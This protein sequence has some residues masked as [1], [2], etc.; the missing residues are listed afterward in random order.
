MPSQDE[1]VIN[2]L[3][4]LPA[5]RRRPS[6]GHTT[7]TGTSAPKRN[8]EVERGKGKG[9]AQGDP[10]K[11]NLANV[12]FHRHINT[13]SVFSTLTNVEPCTQEELMNAS[14]LEVLKQ[15]PTKDYVKLWS[16]PSR[17]CLASQAPQD[18]VSTTPLQAS[19]ATAISDDHTSHAHM[20]DTSQASPSGSVTSLE[21]SVSK[22]LCETHKAPHVRTAPWKLH[23]K[24]YKDIQVGQSLKIICRHVSR[25]FL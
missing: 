9:L 17:Y 11:S 14:T 4:A 12:L 3:H 16:S 2:L 25:T 13:E 22:S 24:N 18:P 6:T 15:L 20:D 21:S 1:G 8:N 7:T 10:S 23:T 19:A 5:S